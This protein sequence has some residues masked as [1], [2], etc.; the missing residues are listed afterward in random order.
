MTWATE[1]WTV[2]ETDGAV[3]AAGATGATS[4]SP[5]AVK[6]PPS[7][8][9]KISTSAAAIAGTVLLSVRADGDGPGRF[10]VRRPCMLRNRSF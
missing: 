2:V 4:S 8:Y 3:G 10:V 7:S 6:I 5:S 1:L 9:S